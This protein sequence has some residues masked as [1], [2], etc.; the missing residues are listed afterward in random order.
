[1]AEINYTPK[2]YFDT[3]SEF[4]GGMNSG[5]A[6]TLLQ[7]NQ[8]AFLLNCS[9]RGGY[10]THR[11]PYRKIPIEF[12]S[13]ATKKTIQTG[14]FQGAGYYKPDYGQESLVAQY[15]GRLFQFQFNG[16]KFIAKDISIANDLNDATAKQ[17]WMWQSEKWLIISDGTGKLP[18][19]FDGVSSRRSLGASTVIGTVS[20]T[21]NPT[22]PPAIGSAVTV[23]LAEK[24]AGQYNVPVIWNGEYYQPIQNTGGYSVLLGNI[25]DTAG[26]TI[27]F[28]AQVV[29]NPNIIGNTTAASTSTAQYF[30]SVSL[31]I[32]PGYAYQS[33]TITWVLQ[34]T[35]VLGLSIGTGI[36]FPTS[37]GNATATVTA[38]NSSTNTVTCSANRVKQSAAKYS[39]PP[40]QLPDALPVET[41]ASGATISY[42]TSQG[43]SY[44]AGTITNAAGVTVPPIGSTVVA[45]LSLLF[46]GP[47]S[48]AFINGK[49]YTITPIAGADTGLTLTMLNLS[50]TSGGAY[51]ISTTAQKIH[52]V[53]EIPACR[54]GQ[55]G[56]GCNCVSLTDG[57]SYVVGDVVGAASGTP[58]NNYRDAV[59]KITQNDFLF[60]GG[61]FRVPS[62]GGLISSITFPAVLDTSLGQGPLQIGTPTKFFSNITPGTD[63]SG[64]SGLTSPIQ[65]VSLIGF[66]PLGQNS[67]I[68]V[69][70][71]TTFRSDVGIGSLVLGRRELNSGAESGGNKTISNEVVRILKDDDRALL[72]Y[73]SAQF[74]DNRELRTVRPKSTQFGVSHA[75]FVCRNFDLLSTLRGALPASWEGLWTGLNAMQVVTGTFSG[76]QRS[77]VF[78]R[79]ALSGVNEIYEITTEAENE[80]LDN[81]DTP[82]VWAFETPAVFNK[83]VKSETELVQLRD[84]EIYLSD[85]VGDVSIKVFYRPDYYPGWVLWN[86]I[87]ASASSIS[88]AK[89]G[90]RMRIGFGEPSVDPVESGN[91]RPLRQ[92]YFF[93]LRLEITGH[94]IVK[95][96]RLAATSQP[97]QVFAPVDP[98]GDQLIQVDVQDDLTLYTLQGTV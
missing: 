64:W 9:I 29:I 90:Y 93:Q 32:S 71:D 63:P 6:P 1:M 83:D 80:K 75:G 92:G 53:P 46:N 38:I 7:K 52:S 36:T 60:G 78:T 20:A 91:N 22:S 59:L 2:K 76:V 45:T 3:L 87:N 14:F 37:A 62:S 70:N 82:I 49:Q 27:P 88:T 5:V 35:S 16:T 74:F 23:T 24:F 98:Q 47:A 15:S 54:M 73:G 44:I 94:C 72:Q 55:Y 31:P 97:T 18:I 12:D 68:Q 42:S 81:G 58:A 39:T 89:P 8:L 13:D 40:S 21:P 10:V 11:P 26:T 43:A 66:G 69:N 48:V 96:I 77:F 25:N 85:I 84:G 61:S 4:T 57:I 34:L 50:D 51:N 95:C 28:G 65:S 30:G 19:F 56:M 86:T 79:N 17:V 67:T 33:Y 41:V